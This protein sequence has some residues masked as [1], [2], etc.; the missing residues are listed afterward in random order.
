MSENNSAI[1]STALIE[2]FYLLLKSGHLTQ[3]EFNNKK[4][5]LLSLPEFELSNTNDV[6]DNR[7]SIPKESSEV[8]PSE[9][10]KQDL[11]AL[12][13]KCRETG[14]LNDELHAVKELI[15]LGIPDLQSRLIEL[16]QEIM[17]KDKKWNRVILIA[18]A[19]AI[20]FTAIPLLIILI[21]KFL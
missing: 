13:R 18:I 6:P 2:R 20:A 19:G 1:D 17:I 10:R 4:A 3:E 7:I 5:D 14:A 12:M 9:K 21:K 11:L 16:Q 8:D 15:S